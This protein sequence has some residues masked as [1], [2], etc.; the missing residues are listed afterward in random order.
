MNEFD[1]SDPAINE[2]TIDHYCFGCGNGNPA[3]L[4]LRFRPLADGRVWAEFVPL[5]QHEG[6]LGMT[7]GGILATILDEAMSWAVT[8]A[9]DL[10]VTARMTTT[11]RHPVRLGESLRVVGSIASRRSRTIETRAEL[12]S[13]ATGT[14]LAEAEGRFVRVSREQAAAWRDA[15]GVVDDESVFGQAAMRNARERHDAQH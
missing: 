14:L 15:Y 2:D 7:H 10:G 1:P 12:F 3:G 13:V 5:R 9:G 4:R 6:Y 11:F 8:N